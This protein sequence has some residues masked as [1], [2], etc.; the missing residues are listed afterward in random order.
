M[1][2]E[3]ATSYTLDALNF[4]NVLTQDEF[5]VKRHVD[6]HHRFQAF[7]TEQ[8]Q[9]LMSELIRIQG[10]TMLSPFL[11]LVVSSVPDFDSIELSELL[12]S[13]DLLESYFSQTPYYEKEDWE[14]RKRL[15]DLVP[16]TI[17]SLEKLGFKEYWHE[18]K[19]PYLIGKGEEI[20]TFAS[21]Y[22]IF[23]EINDMLGPSSKIDHIILY[24][25]SYAAPHGIKI[26]GP[27]YISDV[28]FRMAFTLGVAIHEMF[29]PPYRI[30]Q[31]DDPFN[32]LKIEPV[33]LAAFEKQKERFGYSTI[34]GFIEENVVEA[35]AL[36]IWDKISLEKDPYGYL[37]KHDEGSHLLSVVLLKYMQNHPKRE[38]VNFQDYFNQF[39]NTL[40]FGTEGGIWG[41]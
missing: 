23:K 10:R 29:H 12:R 19:R 21:Q 2:F 35:M 22:S 17:H 14:Q 32:K 4:L 28:S 9:R 34:K 18:Q 33:L 41:V 36:Y 38:A 5:Y 39:L 11:T 40:P 27:R 3:V 24:L 20:A 37:E 8:N 26:A 15:F 13:T 1:A 16:E 31:L 30:E 6:D 25:C 7:H